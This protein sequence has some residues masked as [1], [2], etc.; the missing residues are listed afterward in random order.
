M[1]LRRFFYPKRYDHFEPITTGLNVEYYTACRGTIYPGDN[2]H[3][4]VS[5]CQTRGCN[6][7]HRF[8]SISRFFGIKFQGIFR[9]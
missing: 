9:K 1:F 2:I 3:D 7:E 6:P 5:Y 8:N 4:P